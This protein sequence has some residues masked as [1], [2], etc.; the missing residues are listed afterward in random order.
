MT[1]DKFRDFGYNPLRYRGMSMEALPKHMKRILFAGVLVLGVA[2]CGSDAEAQT[3][4]HQLSSTFNP[5][6]TVGC[7]NSTVGPALSSAGNYS[8]AQEY[9]TAYQTIQQPT[10]FF[11]C[12]NGLFQQANSLINAFSGNGFNLANILTNLATQMF[13]SLINQLQ[14]AACS[15]ANSLLGS[16]SGPLQPLLNQVQRPYAFQ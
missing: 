7:D 8:Y 10:S 6:A 14:T 13:N 16:N 5:N 15:A 12:L 1:L 2:L 9:N 11:G 4:G 3:I